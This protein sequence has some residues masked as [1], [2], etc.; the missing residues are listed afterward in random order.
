M[1][2]ASYQT[3]PSPSTLSTQPHL[4]P[5]PPPL[6]SIYHPSPITAHRN[7]FPP[8]PLSPSLASSTFPAVSTSPTTPTATAT[9][10]A[11]SMSSSSSSSSSPTLCKY[12]AS[13]RC[14]YGD[15]CRFAHL[16]PLTHHH[17]NNS[18]PSPQYPAS[19]QAVNDQHTESSQAPHQQQISPQFQIRSSPSQ[20]Q[21]ALSALSLSNT[22]IPSVVSSSTHPI[23]HFNSNDYPS[24]SSTSQSSSSSSP[25]SS[26]TT[27]V[28]SPVPVPPLPLHRIT[29]LSVN[30][31]PVQAAHLL[32]E[33]AK[34]HHLQH[35][36]H[37]DSAFFM[38]HAQHDFFESPPPPS[39]SSHHHSSSSTPPSQTRRDRVCKYFSLGTC[40]YGTMCS[41]V[42]ASTNNNIHNNTNTAAVGDRKSVV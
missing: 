12:F 4:H 22:P 2:S 8:T 21:Q 35:Q 23:A 33:L 34:Q 3:L 7:S 31:Q 37:H 14:R 1:T 40:R 29:Q 27:L 30:G 39:S 19:S 24:V 26:V 13:Q 42:H 28:G 5:Q 32:S 9:A 17:N 10:A 41:F 11:N 20:L 36:Q 18:N 6:H 16:Q 15:L 25:S 38:K